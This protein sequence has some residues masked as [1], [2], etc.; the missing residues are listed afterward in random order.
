[1]ADNADPLVTSAPNKPALKLGL[2]SYPVLQAADILLYNATHVPVG[3]DQAQHLEFTRE[4]GNSINHL[5]AKPPG[6]SRVPFKGFFL[7]QTIHSPAKRIMSLQ[8]PT[9][10]MS[11]SDPDERSRILITDSRDEINLKIKHA[12]TDSVPGVSYDRDSRPGVSNLIDIMYYMDES[13]YGSPE[14]IAADMFSKDFSLKVL[15]EQVATTVADGLEPIR[16]RYNEQMARSL[17]DVDA[18]MGRGAS[19]AKGTAA[20]N[21]QRLK[22]AMGIRQHKHKASMS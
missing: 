20:M 5:Y 17:E 19:M 1:M 13:K 9:K 8:D 11:K 15:K 6:P 7:P 4:L 14:E 3:E 21:L 10:K 18:E 2:F 12:L 22:A 16:E